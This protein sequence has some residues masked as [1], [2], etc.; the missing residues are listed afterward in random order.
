MDRL[1]AILVLTILFALTSMRNLPQ[2]QAV[3]VREAPFDWPQTMKENGTNCELD[4]SQHDLP[5]ESA[6][7][8][9]CRSISCC[10]QICVVFIAPLRQRWSVYSH[11]VDPEGTE[12]SLFANFFRVR[13]TST[14]TPTHFCS[15]GIINPEKSERQ[16]RYFA[17][18]AIEEATGIQLL[19]MLEDLQ[20]QPNQKG[21]KVLTNALI[22]VLQSKGGVF[23]LDSHIESAEVSTSG[24]LSLSFGVC[25]FETLENGNYKLLCRSSSEPE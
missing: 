23:L 6:I 18:S 12:L 5:H 17:R 3:E 10:N 8:E 20:K 24:L 16:M 21:D 2:S 13:Q 11:V 4:L 9:V 15:W 7:S 19:R 22:E 25:R 14:G 1:L